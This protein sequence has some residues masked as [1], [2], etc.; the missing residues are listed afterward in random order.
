M[1]DT[2]VKQYLRGI[3]D[4]VEDLKRFFELIVVIV[5]DRPNPGLDF[6]FGHVV[7]FCEDVLGRRSL[8]ASTTWLPF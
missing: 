7:S 5:S 2:A 4:V 6:L 8:P 1:N 3:G